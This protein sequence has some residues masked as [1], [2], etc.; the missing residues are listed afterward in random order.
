MSGRLTLWPL[1]AGFMAKTG[2]VARSVAVAAAIVALA[3]QMAAAQA[4][5]ER[6]NTEEPETLDP[7]LAVT[8]AE[9]NILRDLYE[10]LVT[11]DAQGALI[12]GGAERWEISD[13]GLVYTFH[14]RPGMRWSDG[15]TLIAE[16]FANGLRRLFEPFVGAPYAHLYIAVG[17]AEDIFAGAGTAEILAVRSVDE[18]TLQISLNRP[19]PQFLQLLALPAAMP[20]HRDHLDVPPIPASDSPFNGAYKLERAETGEGIWLVRNEAFHDAA[21]VAIESVVYRPWG[22]QQA[23]RAFRDGTLMTNNDV[24]A[25]AISDRQEEFGA[26]LRHSRYVGTYFYAANLE[27][28]L[29]DPRLRRAVALAIDRV[30]LNDEVWSG[31]M[32][33]TRA[34]LPATL[35]ITP[36]PAEADLGANEREA[37]LAE[38]RS[39]L[40]TAGFNP[41]NPLTL[42]I[43]VAST[44]LNRRTAEA[45]VADL[46]EAGIR[47][48]IS[49]RLPADHYSM[50]TTERNWDLASYAWIGDTP[51]PI[52]F[53]GL[54]DTD[55]ENITG[56]FSPEFE[57]LLAE[58]ALMQDRTVADALYATAD[59]T[60]V[61]GLPAI[62]LLQYGALN[63]VSE[64]VT[65]WEDNVLDVHLTRWLSLAE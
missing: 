31:T 42:T 63:L 26:T 12:P 19:T 29:L 6:G 28:T 39:L 18:L 30:A 15:T 25:F 50:L 34:L 14:I 40:E 24:P 59:R 8:A 10:G 3:P 52:E 49:E 17:G 13:D 5:Y 1:L 61:R 33:P 55:G 51:H 23:L 45:V 57:R 32:F 38:A 43:A 37:R 48:T 53:L 58:A 46:A 27:G 44:E 4:V 36:A 41:N 16:D 22:L 56:F 64:R 65:G 11:Y 9:F 62:P 35:A 47:A 7:Q 54:F 2:T 20:V 21:S 60:L